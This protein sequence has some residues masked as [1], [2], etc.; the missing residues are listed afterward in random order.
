VAVAFSP[1]FEADGTAFAVTGET[2][3]KT[4]DGGVAWRPVGTKV[5]DIALSPTFDVDG[6]AYSLVP[7]VGVRVSHDF[8]ETWRTMPGSDTGADSIALSS[9]FARD[10]TLFA[11]GEDLHWSADGVETWTKSEFV[12]ASPFEP[13]HVE[14]VAFA[15]DYA[16]SGRVYMVLQGRLFESTDRGVRFCQVSTPFTLGRVHVSRSTIYALN[17]ETLY[18]SGDSGTTWSVLAEA[19]G[20]RFHDFVVVDTGSKD[21]V[22]LAVEGNAV[23]ISDDMGATWRA[24]TM[25]FLAGGVTRLWASGEGAAVLG[26][27]PA[28]GGGMF[29]L[30]RDSGA[31]WEAAGD[32]ETA[33]LDY[34]AVS[35]DVQRDSMVATIAGGGVA[36]SHDMGESWT[37]TASPDLEPSGSTPTTVAFSP[38]FTE[39]KTLYAGGGWGVVKSDDGGAT[40]RTVYSRAGVWALDA[41]ST[42]NGIVLLAAIAR[43]LVYSG[44]GGE[45][46]TVV[47]ASP[48]AVRDIAFSPGFAEDQTIFVGTFEQEFYRHTDA[49]ASQ[50]R[51]LR[52]LDGGRSWHVVFQG[53]AFTPPSVVVSADY[54]ED[55][56]VWVTGPEGGVL[57]RSK[58]R[59]FFW[60]WV[61][62]GVVGGGIAECRDG[63]RTALV[64]F[65]GTSGSL[66]DFDQPAFSLD[67]GETWEVVPVPSPLRNAVIACRLD[68]DLTILAGGGSYGTASYRVTVDL[69]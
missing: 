32:I 54:A 61:E 24:A 5:R 6:V 51:F 10:R 30:S 44:D 64:S 62:E 23:L 37:L 13:W 4:S 38:H 31:S 21:R 16:T 50:S 66:A 11:W 2:L 18:A 9:D 47:P 45:T 26:A 22:V 29:W 57:M 46:W 41:V 25:P 56:T 59:G 53:R 55:P 60:E 14:D 1:A 33:A 68:N 40:W 39:D 63:T 17:G 27:R 49:Y 34:L 58:S 69:P 36:M 43:G 67:G 28:T 7:G 8:G 19:K 12:P 15:N 52:S 42:P 20:G 35:P 65:P 48:Q 3:Y